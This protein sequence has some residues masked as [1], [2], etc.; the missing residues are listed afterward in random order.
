MAYTQQQIDD[1]RDA[2]ASGVLTVE[3]A[4]KRITYR[5]LGQMQQVLAAM[6][7]AVNGSTT[8]GPRMVRV[9]QTG[10]GL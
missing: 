4:G 7:V 6:E 1:L 8:A 2:I 9:Y 3:T 10:K 5:D